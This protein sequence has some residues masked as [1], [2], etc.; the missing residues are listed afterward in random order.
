MNVYSLGGNFRYGVKRMNKGFLTLAVD[1]GIDF[2]SNV[3]GRRSDPR[4][5]LLSF[6][7]QAGLDWNRVLN[8]YDSG[9][10][11][12]LDFLAW[13]KKQLGTKRQDAYLWF[14]IGF[15]TLETVGVALRGDAP[16]DLVLVGYR[17]QL[18]KAGV[19]VSERDEI[20]RLI[21]F[22]PNTP[23]N[24]RS[25]VLQNIRELL[26]ERARLIETEEHRHRALTSRPGVVAGFIAAVA[27]AV[28]AGFILNV[29]PNPFQK[30]ADPLLKIE[31][32][33]KIAPKNAHE[34]HCTANGVKIG[35]MRHCEKDGTCENLL[36]TSELCERLYDAAAREQLAPRRSSR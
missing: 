26:R 9:N 35:A 4:P 15:F 32:G 13:L 10:G 23:K 16:L 21:R 24:S 18:D 31:W 27:A 22:L 33:R 8:A 2:S 28:A 17:D 25:A 30:T 19:S 34:Y 14:E 5:E 11:S 7:Q 36:A 3:T 6:F 29:I 1:A 12:G 20:A